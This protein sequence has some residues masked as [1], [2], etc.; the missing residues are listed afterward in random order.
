MIKF[1]T[2]E[3]IKALMEVINKSE[4][5]AQAARNW[6]GDF[7]FIVEPGEG[8]DLQLEEG[9]QYQVGLE[10]GKGEFAISSPAVFRGGRHWGLCA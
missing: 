1:A 5:Y 8:A 2:D 4:A 6:E 10:A 3:W 7:Y 9:P